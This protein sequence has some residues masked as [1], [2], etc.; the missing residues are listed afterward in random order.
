M[1]VKFQDKYWSDSAKD[2][3]DGIAIWYVPMK[4]G[5]SFETCV[6]EIADV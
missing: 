3:V 5:Q 1:S 4:T 6:Q 2:W